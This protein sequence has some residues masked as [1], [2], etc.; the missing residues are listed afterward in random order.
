M[1]S[2]CAT[3]KGP[4]ATLNCGV[5][6]EKICKSCASFADELMVPLLEPMP[7]YFEHG[8]FC[9]SCFQ[10]QI[11]GEI[12]EYAAILERAHLVDI[13]YKTQSKES[14]FVRR[15]E[16]PIRVK[17]CVDRDFTV[18][19]LAFLAARDGFNIL[20][21]VEATSEKV[22]NGGWQTSNWQGVGTPGHVDQEKLSRRMANS[23][24]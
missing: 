10:T 21:D 18:L 23:P 7:S 22:R 16:K 13:F 15:T 17:D 11:V 24:N 5:C 4:K 19:K 3:C 12:A 14:R 8:V 1:E 6:D 2:N 9:Q 20:L